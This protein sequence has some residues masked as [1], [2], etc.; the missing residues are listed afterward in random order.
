MHDSL[1]R[2]T[3]PRRGDAVELKGAFSAALWYAT[4]RF[5]AAVGLLVVMPL[6][7]LIFAA[8]KLTSPGPFIYR[9][10]RPGLHGKP[11]TAYKIRSMR[12]GADREVE[13][14]RS[15][16]ASH[17]EVTGV[18]RVLRDL[19]L[20]ELPQ[21]WNVVRGDMALVGPRPIAIALQQELEGEIE[22]FERRLSVRPGLTNLGQVCV[23]ESA[24]PARVVD[25]W[26]M[27][28]EAERHYLENRS[29]VYDVL[30]VLITAMYV[31]RKALMRLRPAPRRAALAATALLAVVVLGGCASSGPA[32]SAGTAAV[33][34]ERVGEPSAAAHPATQAVERV[35]VRTAAKGEPE[36]QYRVGP[37]DTLA[38]NVFGEPG[39]SDLRVPVDA[40]GYIQLPIVERALV[41]GKTT[42][43]IQGQLKAAFAR[44]F[45]NPWVV[46][47]VENF[48]S[49]PL[50]L[51]GEFN[52]PGVVYL[53]RP[54][55]I[56][57]ALGHGKGLSERAFLRGARLLRDD[58][59]VPVDINGLLKEGRA[60][61]N[62][63]LEAGD[64]IYVPNL[65]DQKI[66]VLGAVNKPGTMPYGNDGVGLLEVIARADGERRGSARLEQVRVIRSLSPVAG[67]F[68]TV[69]AERIVAGAS[70]DFPLLAGDIVY[71][72]QNALGDWNDV[73]NAVKPSFELVVSSL[74]PFVQLKFLTESD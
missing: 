42:T 61:Q 60:D 16:R 69:D 55:N 17:P 24:D 27:R 4:Q 37:G 29:A 34:T 53:D 12:Q 62:L 26:R 52:D 15:V 50:Y 31:S 14:A 38:V 2:F 73:V 39:M 46:A 30:I 20:D 72:P 13:L 64:T 58:A 40:D 25:D 68:I 71:V 22:G 36:P 43:E 67:E 48:G 70:P 44:E 56:V 23:L 18:G 19:K 1:S 35:R 63:W 47:L 65:D 5:L 8:V 3:S 57:Q 54:T 66:I 7:P 28:F 21:L 33:S 11:F 41:A 74:Q 9:Q 59:L 45:N 49:R 6:V 10:E 32:L 51:L